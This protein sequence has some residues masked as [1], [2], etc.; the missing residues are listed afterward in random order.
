MTLLEDSVSLQLIPFFSLCRIY[1]LVTFEDV[2]KH[3]LDL[4]K[5]LQLSGIVFIRREN[6]LYRAK[7]ENIEIRRFSISNSKRLKDSTFMNLFIDRDL[8]CNQGRA[9]LSRREES[10]A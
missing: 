6:K 5:V 4:D 7:I 8:T 10:A 9:L 2:W 1:F 3:I